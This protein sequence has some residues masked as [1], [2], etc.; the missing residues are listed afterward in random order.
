MVF[1]ILMCSSKIGQTDK[2]TQWKHKPQ[3]KMKM[4]N[5]RNTNIKWEKSSSKMRRKIAKPNE[6]GANIKRQRWPTR[7]KNVLHVIW[8]ERTNREMI[9]QSLI[10]NRTEPNRWTFYCSTIA[11]KSYFSAVVQ[12]FGISSISRVWNT[13]Y[14]CGY[15]CAHIIFSTL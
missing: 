3:M 7:I 11:V 9:I 5:E 10:L 6:N 15:I 8:D 12:Y 14:Q 4:K 13:S 2:K 1:N